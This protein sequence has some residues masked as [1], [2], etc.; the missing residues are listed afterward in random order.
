MGGSPVYIMDKKLGKG[1]F[2]Q[3]YCGKRS[4]PTKD[5]DG[6]NANLVRG[7]LSSCLLL[8]ASSKESHFQP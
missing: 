6:S 5:T 3:V 4:T 1:G 8:S 7:Y 2:G